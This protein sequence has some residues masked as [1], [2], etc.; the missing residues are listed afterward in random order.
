MPRGDLDG[1]RHPG[2]LVGQDR[3]PDLG[4]WAILSPNTV[5]S[6]HPEGPTMAAEILTF[7]P[8]VSYNRTCSIINMKMNMG[9]R[10]REK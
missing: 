3:G 10:E 2:K 7:V 8:S 1:L 6:M 9:F 5:S 4:S